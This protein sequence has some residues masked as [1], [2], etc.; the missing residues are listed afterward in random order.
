MYEVVG[1]MSY[2]CRTVAYPT[3]THSL[4]LPT[5][6]LL[7]LLKNTCSLL[8]TTPL[9]IYMCVRDEDAHLRLRL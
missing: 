1:E 2:A 6:S 9:R 5:P 3:S 7:F 4:K 8:E